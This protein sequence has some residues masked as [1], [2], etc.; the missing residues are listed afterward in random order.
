MSRG[1]TE[2]RNPEPYIP[3][4]VIEQAQY[5]S[6]HVKT[7]K[8]A[9]FD[10]VHISSVSTKPRLSISCENKRVGSEGRSEEG[11]ELWGFFNS[12]AGPRSQRRAISMNTIQTAT[13]PMSARIAGH[14]PPD[15][16]DISPPPANT[17]SAVLGRT[18]TARAITGREKCGAKRTA[19]KISEIFNSAGVNAGTPNRP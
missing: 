2:V 5:N 15:R 10:E 14:P 13:I 4:K 19:H 18:P 9:Q 17:T 7:H 11:D 1:S 16:S 8:R 12:V 6:G 3:L